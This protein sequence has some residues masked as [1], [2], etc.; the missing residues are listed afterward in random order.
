M[1]YFEVNVNTLFR[2]KMCKKLHLLDRKGLAAFAVGSFC[3][4]KENI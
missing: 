1:P 2:V 4:K 3:L